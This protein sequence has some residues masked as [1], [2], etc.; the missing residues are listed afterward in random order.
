MQLRHESWRRSSTTRIHL[1]SLAVSY[2]RTIHTYIHTQM[3]QCPAR[4]LPLLTCC[5][6]TAFL[7]CP[8]C[9]ARVS[10]S[11][12]RRIDDW[13]APWPC[14][15]LVNWSSTKTS[16][17]AKKAGPSGHTDCDVASIVC[18]CTVTE[19]GDVVFPIRA[20]ARAP[21]T[22]AYMW[23]TTGEAALISR[24]CL[25]DKSLPERQQR[26]NQRCNSF[27]PPLL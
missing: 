16:W 2:I 9:R 27:D 12:L 23:W 1:L 10:N 15:D 20:C 17:S 21:I 18:P 14:H 22:D 26:I 24:R 4:R 5:T 3:L 8:A 13:L 6:R 11:R 19:R 25:R 7:S